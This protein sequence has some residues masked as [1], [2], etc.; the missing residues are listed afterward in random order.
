MPAGRQNPDKVSST[1]INTA[2]AGSLQGGT[3][4]IILQSSTG[5]IQAQAA[6]GGTAGGTD[7]GAGAI[8]L[9]S[10]RFS[11][12]HVAGGVRSGILSGASNSACGTEGVITGGLANLIAISTQCFVGG[13]SYNT[14][15]TGYTHSSIVGGS[16]GYVGASYSV[17]GGGQGNTISASYS[18]IGAGTLNVIQGLAHDSVIGGG[19]SNVIYAPHCFIA[20]GQCNVAWSDMSVISGGFGNVARGV[21]SWIPGGKYARTTHLGEGAYA[22][23]RLVSDGDTQRSLIVLSGTSLN[24][25]AVRLNSGD[26]GDPSIHVGRHEMVSCTVDLT[27]VS[28]DGASFGAAKYFF[29]CQILGTETVNLSTPILIAAHGHEE[30]N[31]FPSNWVISFGAEYD[32]GLKCGLLHVDVTDQSCSLTI[33]EDPGSV[34]SGGE[35]TTLVTRGVDSREEFMGNNLGHFNVQIVPEL[36]PWN[37]PSTNIIGGW[38]GIMEEQM[39][40]MNNFDAQGKLYVTVASDSGVDVRCYK[41]SDHTILVAQGYYG[42]SFSPGMNVNL[43]PEA[44]FD[45]QGPVTVLQGYGSET[46]TFNLGYKLLLV[47]LNAYGYEQWAAWSEVFSET[48][49]IPFTGQISGSITV[50]AL[51][52]RSDMTI[53]V[54]QTRWMAH[55]AM[56]RVTF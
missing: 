4:P 25:N 35:V 3:S 40:S 27:G 31:A 16:S 54:K 19:N 24:G 15:V 2:L 30:S 29:S 43:S 52:Y 45:L 50:N 13:G 51:G 47:Y 23:S 22:T 11:T 8:D 14:I 1:T 37:P 12:G 5:K 17:V 41:D 21:N 10:T 56:N 34:L 46:I 36:D 9:Q 44:G 18:M 42:G 55:F 48:G 6:T 26:A 32:A 38:G 28:N 33:V 39:L 53:L 7:R 49:V 20:G